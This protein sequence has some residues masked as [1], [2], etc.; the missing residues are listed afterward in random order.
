MPK[1]SWASK[2]QQYWLYAQLPD[3][4]ITQDAKMT[5]SFFSKI[6]EEFHAQW[7]GPSPTAEGIAANDG[8]EE[9]AQTIKGKANESVSD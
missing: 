9:Q 6:Y 8:N 4:C 2:D 3:F 5:P 7:P 1:K